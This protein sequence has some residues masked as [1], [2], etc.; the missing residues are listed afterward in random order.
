MTQN[1][2]IKTKTFLLFA[3]VGGLFYVINRFTPLYD[4]DWQYR[5]IFG[6]FDKVDSFADI[7]KSQYN[8][9][10]NHGNGRIFVHTV[11]QFFDCIV[12]KQFFNVFNA[13]MFL[14]F[15]HVAT[16]NASG[17]SKQ[18]LKLAVASIFMVFFFFN[19]FKE[20]FLWMTG[21]CNYLMSGTLVLIFSHIMKINW[22]GYKHSGIIL[23]LLFLFSCL[24][25]SSNEALVLGLEVGYIVHFIIYRRDLDKSRMLLLGGFAFGIA[26]LCL[27]PAL[28][29]RAMYFSHKGDTIKGFS[30]N[31][32]YGMYYLRMFYIMILIVVLSFIINKKFDKSRFL[33]DNL[34]WIIAIFVSFFLVVSMT[35]PTRRSLFGVELFSLM[36]T[37]N[38]LKNVNFPRIC[39]AL[40]SLSVIIVMIILIPLCRSNYRNFINET[41]Q[42]IGSEDRFS[43]VVKTGSMVGNSFTDRWVLDYLPKCKNPR[44]RFY[45][46]YHFQRIFDKNTESCNIISA[47]Y[48]NPDLTLTFI[49]NAWYND[50]KTSHNK[51]DEYATNDSLPFYAKRID[52]NNVFHEKAYILDNSRNDNHIYDRKLFELRGDTSCV[53]PFHIRVLPPSACPDT[54]PIVSGE[55]KILYQ[56]EGGQYYLI[57]KYDVV[58]DKVRKI[59]EL[60]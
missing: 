47:F 4:D 27:S 46:V 48:G 10:L 8:H 38:L 26:I 44:C 37:L 45:G 32:F 39:L 20:E 55:C 14:C 31:F 43:C 57:P 2:I 41:S 34:I 11:V 3:I 19:D 16:I 22:S 23:L 53:I 60:N 1:C 6:T 24:C 59:I 13:I 28:F 7:I 56:I 30:L 33:K 51:Y 49:P 21:S 25:G 52:W 12:G 54:V 5:L 17:D 58:K 42:I 40:M 9:Y 50:L 36:I 35:L 29:K 15:I 18:Y